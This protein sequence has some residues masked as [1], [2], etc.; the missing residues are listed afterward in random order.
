MRKI[1]F[2]MMLLLIICTKIVCATPVTIVNG[3]NVITEDLLSSAFPDPNT[4]EFGD[5]FTG[6]SGTTYV[7]NPTGD[8]KVWGQI[9]GTASFIPVGIWVVIAEGDNDDGGLIESEDIS[10]LNTQDQGSEPDPN[11]TEIGDTFTGPSGTEYI[12]E[13]ENISQEEEE[14]LAQLGFEPS[15][16]WVKQ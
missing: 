3:Q 4:T 5:Q 13:E 15:G 11:D 10:N 7:F 12:L 8:V 6:P 9:G 1:I 16:V 14:A 2:L